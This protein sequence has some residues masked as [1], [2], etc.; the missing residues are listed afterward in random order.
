M[1]APLC[2]APSAPVFPR[3]IDVLL[4]KGGYVVA[5]IEAYFDESYGQFGGGPVL[6]LAGYLMESEQA[7]RL[8]EE[9]QAVLDWKGLP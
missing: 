3:L 1:N 9:W 6:C 7:K 8:C 2:L 4:P 5:M